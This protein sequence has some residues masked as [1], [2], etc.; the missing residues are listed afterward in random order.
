MYMPIKIHHNAKVSFVK[1]FILTDEPDLKKVKYY[2][3]IKTQIKKN[4]ME[5]DDAANLQS[6]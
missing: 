1:C 4:I 5:K 2:F 6:F 3:P